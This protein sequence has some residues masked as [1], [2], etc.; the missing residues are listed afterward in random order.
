MWVSV[1][2][3]G[4]S[5]RARRVLDVDRVAGAQLGLH[6]RQ[7]V[8]VDR[9]VGDLLP[10]LPPDD[11]HVAERGAPP[12][13][14]VEHRHVVGALELGRR[15]HRAHRRLVQHVLELVGPVGGVDV[16]QD[17]ADLRGGVLDH[18]PLGAVR[19]PDPDPV[20]RLGAAFD[21]RGGDPAGRFVELAVGPAATR[22][23]LDERL[24]VRE[25]LR[26]SWR[27][28]RRSSRRAAAGWWLRRRRTTCASSSLRTVDFRP[29]LG[30]R[31]RKSDEEGGGGEMSILVRRCDS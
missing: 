21:Q 22:R 25:G 2:P 26:S 6:P 7:R 5:G 19:R 14:V 12:A 13:H 20:A 3:L 10:R 15:E 27:G 29:S 30:T 4:K 17:R 9:G 31:H 16:H 23:A 11:D 1:A 28:C 8:G 24:P 18:R